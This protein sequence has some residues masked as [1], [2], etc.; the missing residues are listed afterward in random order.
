[1]TT[2][3]RRGFLG[4]A[5]ST[6]AA[7]LIPGTRAHAADAPAASGF[8]FVHMTDIHVQ[9]GRAADK[10]MAKALAAAESLGTKPDFIMTGGDLVMDVMDQDAATSKGL[11]DLFKKTLGDGTG[12]PVHHCIGN[13]DV[14]GWGHKKGTTPEHPEYGKRMVSDA[15][16][17]AKPYHAFDHKGWRFYALDSIQPSPGGYVGYIDEE[18]FDWLRRDLESKPAATPAV[19]VTHIPILTVTVIRETGKG[20]KDD[21]Y[22]IPIGGMC[23][24]ANTLTALFAKHNVRLALSGH[25]HQLDRIDYRGVTFICDGA[26]SGGWWKGPNEGV[27]EGFG[28]LDLAPDGTFTHQ[29]FDYG[30]EA[31]A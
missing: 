17:L 4:A 8:R 7:A 13:H 16:E 15:L 11:F 29:Y 26:V 3:N 22:Q 27:Q 1:M 6:G 20:F 9:T 10:G 31:Q 18:Q 24:G 5:L 30:W 14:F 25:I 21:A 12:L 19:V 28:V 2:I 23:R